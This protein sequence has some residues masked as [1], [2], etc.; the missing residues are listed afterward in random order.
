MSNHFNSS[1]ANSEKTRATSWLKVCGSSK[2]PLEKTLSD[3]VAQRIASGNYKARDVDYIAKFPISLTT[4]A[5]T[6][7]DLQLEKLRRLCQLA[8]V[9]LTPSRITSHRAFIGPVIVAVKKIL[10]SIL[11]VLLKETLR[12]QRDFNAAV[13]AYLTTPDDHPR[14]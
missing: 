14:R 10:F 5:L 7:N 4:G 13:I 3:N 9:Q 1:E 8:D 12:K 2:S 6:I 11:A